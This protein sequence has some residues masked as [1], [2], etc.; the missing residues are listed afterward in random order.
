MNPA[1]ALPPAPVRLHPEVADALRHGQPV[2]ALETAVLTHGLPREPRPGPEGLAGWNATRAANLS[3]S[4]LLDAT[5]RAGGATPA[6]VGMLDGVLLVGMTTAELARL[7]DDRDARKLSARDLGPAAVQRANGGTTVAATVTACRAAGVRVFATGGIGGVHR[8]WSERPDVSADL[9]AMARSPV[10]VVSAGA[11]SILDLPATVEALDSLGVP[12]IG[13]GTDRFPRF[14]SDGDASLGVSA[15]ARDAAEAAR[16][17]MAHWA[18]SPSV[19]VL[20]ANPPPA[21]WAIPS[22]EV[23]SVIARATH[24]AEAAGVRGPS[25]T[26]FLL[27]RL[28]LATEGRTLGTNVAVLESNARA[29]AALATALAAG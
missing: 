13:L 6:T 9:A 23:E 20:V 15:T 11:K 4:L 26:P 25:I 8:G 5:V 18:F 1:D 28:Q 21:R 19:G 22:D 16:M 10:A 7:A 24:E 29:G 2:V 12:V 27:D 14:I 3:L 17:C